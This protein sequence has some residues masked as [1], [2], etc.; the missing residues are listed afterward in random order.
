MSFHRAISSSTALSGLTG[1]EPR[2]CQKSPRKATPVL[3][4]ESRRASRRTAASAAMEASTVRSHTWRSEKR[5]QR[6]TAAKGVGSAGR[7]ARRSI[8]GGGGGRGEQR[9]GARERSEAVEVEEV[10]EEVEVVVVVVVVVVV[11][12]D[13]FAFAFAVC[14]L[15]TVGAASAASTAAAAAAEADFVILLRLS[16]FAAATISRPRLLGVEEHWE[17]KSERAIDDVDVCEI[18]AADEEEFESSAAALAAASRPR[19]IGRGVLAAAVSPR[20]GAEPICCRRG[21]LASERD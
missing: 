1:R 11:A 18:D 9:A 6:W 10:E 20:G 7:H 3:T 17:A 12:A 21:E 19:R 2:A 15:R 8:I 16:A 14:R 13:S 4:E 5:I